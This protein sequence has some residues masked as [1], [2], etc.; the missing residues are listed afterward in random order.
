MYGQ[1]MWKQLI[2]C[3]VASGKSGIELS[4]NNS[5][6]NNN[7]NGDTLFLKHACIKHYTK[8]TS[9]KHIKANSQETPFT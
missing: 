9:Q 5:N 2:F 3:V 7:N 6:N 8:C 1:I 4:N